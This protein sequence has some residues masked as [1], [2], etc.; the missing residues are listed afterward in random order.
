M[1][2]ACRKQL[3]RKQGPW[4]NN[5]GP[6]LPLGFSSL[7]AKQGQCSCLSLERWRVSHSDPWLPAIPSPLRTV[8]LDQQAG[9]YWALSAACCQGYGHPAVCASWGAGC[10]SGTAVRW[11]LALL[12]EETI[13]VEVSWASM[14][15]CWQH[16]ADAQPCIRHTQR[17]LL[18][19]PETS[20]SRRCKAEEQLGLG[21]CGVILGEKEFAFSV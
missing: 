15:E 6:S 1:S 11:A 10:V 19:F 13:S 18:A 14:E 8:T 9:G 16:A 5:L 2:W 12:L 20:C 21:K 7:F 4:H 17:R 3:I